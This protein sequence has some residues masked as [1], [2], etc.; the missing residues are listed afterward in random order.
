MRASQRS[1]AK[2]PL[3]TISAYGPDNR[4]ATKL[5]VGILRRAG[6]KDANPMRNW[7]TNTG[8]VRT[9]PV[10]AA[11]LA[12]WLRSQ[13]IKDTVSYDRIIGC[14]PGVSRLQYQKQ[15]RLQE[16]RQLMLNENLDA[17]SAAGRVGYESA[18]QFSREYSRL[19]GA[20]PQRDV[21]RMR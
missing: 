6:Q 2:Y 10:I 18:S 19:F 1:R 15:L 9:D 4:R 3:A 11:E 12:D 21:S 13:E 7:S 8:N 17:G 14:P 5:V 20:P 16:A